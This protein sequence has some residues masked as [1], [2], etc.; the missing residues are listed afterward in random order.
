MTKAKCRFWNLSAEQKQ[1]VRPYRDHRL[2]CRWKVWTL[3]EARFSGCCLAR[4]IRHWRRACCDRTDFRRLGGVES[5]CRLLH[6]WFP[7]AKAY[8]SDPT[9]D[10]HKGIFEGAGFEVG[11]YPYYNPETVG[12]NLKK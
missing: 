10:N 12:G 4:I 8:V 9:W 2:I 11:T 3:I 1:S 6:R 5:R 7:D